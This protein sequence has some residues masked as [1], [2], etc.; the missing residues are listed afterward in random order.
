MLNADLIEYKR[1][2]IK[3][4]VYLLRDG[5]AKNLSSLEIER[6]LSGESKYIDFAKE[7]VENHLID[8]VR[9]YPDRY[10]KEKVKKVKP[11]KKKRTGKRKCGG[12]LNKK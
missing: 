1:Q 7:C 5:K 12:A 10:K 8:M 2:G 6:C 9:L 3:R 4:I 11:V